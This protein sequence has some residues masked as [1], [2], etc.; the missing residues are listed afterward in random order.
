[1]NL[2]ARTKL[3]VKFKVIRK[4]YMSI[5]ILVILILDLL[6]LYSDLWILSDSFKVPIQDLVKFRSYAA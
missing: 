4:K 1:M 2:V 3:L 5:L 6:I